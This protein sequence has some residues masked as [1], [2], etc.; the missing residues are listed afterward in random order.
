MTYIKSNLSRLAGGLFI[1]LAVTFMA[2]QDAPPALADTYTAV[3][4]ECPDK[5]PWETRAPACAYGQAIQ[6]LEDWET[7]P[8]A[9]GNDL[10][11]W[12]HRSSGSFRATSN[13]HAGDWYPRYVVLDD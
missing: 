6:E 2:V 7:L 12:Q 9:D 3:Q 8:V 4:V 5:K 11:L 1:A 10:I 13:P